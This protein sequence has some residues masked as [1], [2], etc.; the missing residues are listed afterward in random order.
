M[1]GKFERLANPKGQLEWYGPENT[2]S[3]ARDEDLGK[4][5]MSSTGCSNEVNSVIIQGRRL[6]QEEA[7][8]E[9]KQG[10][11]AS[12]LRLNVHAGVARG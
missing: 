10:V 7:D 6:G 9:R 3:R 1:D 4:K 11:Y 2:T 12:I 5:K 8:L